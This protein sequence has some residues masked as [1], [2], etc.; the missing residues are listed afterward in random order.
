MK[1]RFVYD[2]NGSPFHL[3]G[4]RIHEE[5]DGT[6]TFE[7]PH[8]GLHPVPRHKVS[9]LARYARKRRPKRTQPERV[10]VQMLLLA[11]LLLSP[12]LSAGQGP[13]SRPP[14][15]YPSSAAG[16]E[17][18]SEEIFSRFASQVLLLTCDLSADELMRASG[19][20]VSADGIVVTNAHVVEGCR[21]ITATQDTR[22]FAA[23]LRGGAQVLRQEKRHG[24]TQDRGRWLRVPRSLYAGC[25]RWG[26]RICHRKSE[27]TRAVN[28][29]GYRLRPPRGER[30]IVDSA[31]RADLIRKQR[32]GVDE[33]AGGTFG[34]QFLVPERLPRS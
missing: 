14:G 22:G 15:S 12:R 3:P 17:M 20:L 24:G 4:T 13:A 25:P 23:I 5:P 19:V 11:A 26:A 2:A 16:A 6:L 31:L 10:A 7:C 29:G 30:D 34:Y 9:G 32:R 28:F 1:T 27:G 18:P 8:C 21:S 33:L